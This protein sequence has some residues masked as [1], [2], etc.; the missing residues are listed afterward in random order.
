LPARSRRFHFEIVEEVQAFGKEVVISLNKKRA[1]E[2]VSA[3]TLRAPV[4]A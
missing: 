4:R 1:A 3:T 2:G